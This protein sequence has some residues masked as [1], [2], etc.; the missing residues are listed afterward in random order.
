MSLV[1][2]LRKKRDGENLSKKEIY[3][4]VELVAQGAVHDG[5]IGNPELVYLLL[6]FFECLSYW[7]I[8]D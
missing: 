3:S 1:D 6:D 2:I 5:Q 7:H 4:F 8:V